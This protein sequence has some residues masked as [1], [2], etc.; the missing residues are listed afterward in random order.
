MSL[1]DVV[2]GVPEDHFEWSDEE[3]DSI[4]QLFRLLGIGEGGIWG[5]PKVPDLE[6]VHPELACIPEELRPLVSQLKKQE[7]NERFKRYKDVFVKYSKMSG[8][9]APGSDLGEYYV[10]FRNLH[11][12]DQKRGDGSYELQLIIH[13]LVTGTSEKENPQWTVASWTRGSP[14]K[15]RKL[16][17]KVREDVKARRRMIRAGPT[18][19]LDVKYSNYIGGKVIRESC[20]VYTPPEFASNG[21]AGTTTTKPGSPPSGKKARH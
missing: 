16:D 18:G 11:F 21:A 17:K 10:F 15:Y 12:A 2:R 14:Q 19:R 7:S 8:Y 20:S 3:R 6:Y 5:K 9:P 1:V 4:D 13:Y